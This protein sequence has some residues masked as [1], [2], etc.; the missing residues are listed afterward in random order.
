MTEEILHF[1]TSSGIKSIVGRDLITD[2]FVA[3]FELVKNSYD[4]NATQVQII[5]STNKIII[6]DDGHGM[7]KE[8]IMNKW[9]NLAY[10]DKQEGTANHDRAFVGSKGIGRFSADRLGQKLLIKTKKIGEENYHKLNVDWKKFDIDLTK[11]FEAVDVEY[12]LKESNKV[13]KSYTYLEISEL[14]EVWNTDQVNKAKESLR[15]LK[16]PFVKN[17]GFEIIVV[18]ELNLIPIEEKIQSNIAEV[19]KDKSIT[20]EANFN[21]KIEVSLF[22][23]GEKIYQIEE[24]NNS[25]LKNCPIKVNI[26]YLTYSSKL[27]FTRRM[28]VEPVN[29]GNV[30]IY[31][32]NFRVMPYGERDYDLFSLNMRK[33]QGHSRYL[34]TRELLGFIDIKD[35]RNEFFKE[36]SSRDS[37][38]VNSIYLKELEYLYLSYI[39]RP[40]EHYVGLISWGEV[41]IDDTGDSKEIYINDVSINSVEKFKSYI[42]KNKNLIF[43]K[44]GLNFEDNKPEKKLDKIIKTIVKEE[45]KILIKPIVNEL[46][47]TVNE[48]KKIQFLSEK[49]INEQNS[50]LSRLEQQN[51]NLLKKRSESSYGEQLSH[52]LTTYTDRL[53]WVV[54]DLYDFYNKLDNEIKNELIN[55]IRTVQRTKQELSIFKDIL[56]RSDFDTRAKFK[57]KLNDILVWYIDEKKISFNSLE[58][59]IKNNFD[60]F[61]ICNI[62]ELILT[63]DNFYNNA[64]SHGAKFLQFDFIKDNE[65]LISSDSEKIPKNLFEKVFELGFSTKIRGTGIGLDQ[66]RNFFKKSK[67]SIKLVDSVDLVTFRVFKG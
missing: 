39:H 48:Y 1:K 18:N 8:D 43:F 23:R 5:F 41:K 51:K 38:F 52:H 63:L 59:I 14:N 65:L 64:L 33:T 24:N 22:D 61:I 60:F 10:S 34:G 46:K 55:T 49:K 4:A 54:N 45:E 15:R 11:L 21:E 12:N 40:L 44:T 36:A 32:N 28:K 29:Y 30:F 42:S 19:L 56:I 3:I 58:I 47:N 67:Y 7:S 62:V 57:Y 25:I 17:D 66:V 2:K 20:I 16:N 13:N 37:G 6:R 50:E 35:I 31:K 26:N 53:D 27:T 9:L